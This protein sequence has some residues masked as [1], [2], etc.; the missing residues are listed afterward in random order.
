[1]Y[2]SKCKEREIITE[3]DYFS[4][5]L[6]ANVVGTIEALKVVEFLNRIYGKLPFKT[7]ISD[8]GKEFVYKL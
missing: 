8:N 3:I 4:R 1:M 7:I 2:W 5:R 6:F